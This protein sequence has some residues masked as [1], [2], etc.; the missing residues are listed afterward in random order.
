MSVRR[1][2]PESSTQMPIKVRFAE[3]LANKYENKDQPTIKNLAEDIGVNRNT[4]SSW[5]R[6][7]VDG[8][9]FRTLEKLCV[10]LECTPGELIIRVED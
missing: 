7:H 5:I 2:I 1:K 4:V 3:L 9:D 10:F 6:G 8:T